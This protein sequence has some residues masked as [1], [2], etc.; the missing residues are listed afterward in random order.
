MEIKLYP[1]FN[2]TWKVGD[3]LIYE[4]TVVGVNGAPALI[5]TNFILV[6]AGAKKGRQVIFVDDDEPQT[7]VNI[8]ED[9]RG[10]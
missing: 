3:R 2:H 10:K 5:T 9:E 4:Q 8:Q 7:L 1:D 6:P